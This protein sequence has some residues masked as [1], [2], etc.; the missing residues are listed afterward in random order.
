VRIAARTIGRLQNTATTTAR[1][2]S[3]MCLVRRTAIDDSERS[4]EDA[5]RAEVA[6]VLRLNPQF[7]L[8]E[9]THPNRP[10]SPPA[11][12]TNHWSADLRKAD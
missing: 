3:L 9:Y 7:I 10:K 12:S 1:N 11:R 6:Q 2:Q 5:G 8:E 4:H